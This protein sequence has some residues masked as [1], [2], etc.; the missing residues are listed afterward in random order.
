MGMAGARRRNC[1][2]DGEARGPGR[3]SGASRL[4]DRLQHMRRSAMQDG[5]DGVEAQPIETIFLDPIGG[6]VSEEGT[7]RLLGEVD[8]RPPGCLMGVGEE[9]GGVAMQVVPVWS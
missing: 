1:A 6:V 3:R 4:G 9:F 7:Y 5:M 8:G 2:R